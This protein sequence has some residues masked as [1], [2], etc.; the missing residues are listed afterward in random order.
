[1]CVHL[2]LW[3]S[4]LLRQ[5]VNH[6]VYVKRTV[7]WVIEY[8]RRVVSLDTCS[9]NSPEEMDVVEGE[10]WRKRISSTARINLPQY[11]FEDL[12]LGHAQQT[13]FSPHELLLMV[14]ITILVSWCLNHVK[15]F[16][17]SFIH[18]HNKAL[19]R[20]IYLW[21]GLRQWMCIIEVL[22]SSWTD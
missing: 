8:Q 11:L 3:L 17:S 19:F 2:L 5:P 21:G 18:M 7:D 13:Y 14:S 22:K 4:A 15:N 20:R 9:H 1:M 10:R 6:S 12:F 16:T